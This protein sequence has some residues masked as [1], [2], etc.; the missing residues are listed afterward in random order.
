[1]S[2]V[3]KKQKTALY[4]THF[5][6]PIFIFLKYLFK[7]LVDA[8]IDLDKKK[9]FHRDIKLS[10]LLVEFGVRMP[11]VRIIDFGCGCYD[12]GKAYRSFCGSISDCCS[13]LTHGAGACLSSHLL[14]PVCVLQAPSSSAPQSGSVGKYTKLVPRQCGRWEWCCTACCTITP[15]TPPS[16]SAGSCPSGPICPQVRG[17]DVPLTV[18]ERTFFKRGFNQK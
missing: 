10:N 18:D 15:S 14:F 12:Q 5:D 7:Q 9:I 8:A 13:A 16:S 4:A 2:L 6:C 11:R 17:A 1:M 3:F